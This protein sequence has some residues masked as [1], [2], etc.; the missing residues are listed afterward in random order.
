MQVDVVV[1]GQEV[2]FSLHRHTCP[3]CTPEEYEE[4]SAEVGGEVG[5]ISPDLECLRC[6]EVIYTG[7]TLSGRDAQALVD[8]H[9]CVV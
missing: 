2:H 6:H 5:E 7:A 9:I 1:F 3:A 4:P 8:S